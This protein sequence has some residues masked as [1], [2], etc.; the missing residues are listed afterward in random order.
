MNNPL[1]TV[2]VPVYKVPYESL[3]KC[4]DSLAIQTSDNFEALMIDDGSPDN[5][6]KICDEYAQK[7]DNFRVIH[8]ENGGLSIVR[9]NGVD[10]AQGQW[11]SFVDGDDWIEPE[12]IAFAEGYVK[13]C[14]DADV[15]NICMESPF[16][17]F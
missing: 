16:T 10:N 8:Q 6:G 2:V 1:I 12:T 7:Y 13:E 3:R 9:N 17:S 15:L 4:L 5:C 11:V 14:A